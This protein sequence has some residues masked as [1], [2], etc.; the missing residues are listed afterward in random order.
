MVMDEAETAGLRYDELAR[1]EIAARVNPH[2]KQYDSRSGIAGYYRYGPRSVSALCND[3]Q[4]GVEVANA[5]VHVHAFDRIARQQ[6]AYAPVSLDK[7]FELIGGNPAHY[8]PSAFLKPESEILELAWDIVWWRRLAYFAT[9]AT[10][11]FIGLFFAALVYRWPNDLLRHIENAIA[12]LVGNNVETAAQSLVRKLGG[13]LAGIL[14]GWLAA[15]LPEVSEYPFTA[16]LSL[17]LLALLFFK[18]SGA[19]Q[20][21]ID[22]YAE[23]AWGDQKGLWPASVPKSTLLN[24]IARPGRKASAFVHRTLWLGIVVNLVGICLGVVALVVLSPYY[25][26]LARRRR[27]WMA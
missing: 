1:D 10:T 14:P 22:A 19:L 23:W 17:A 11:I 5:H 26:W 2:G 21:R 15:V 13:G 25:A 6:R 9:V 27:P 7:P 18:V 16:A 8:P 24:A 4:H 20:R 12:A 3:K